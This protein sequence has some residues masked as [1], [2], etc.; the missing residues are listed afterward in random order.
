MKNLGLI[1]IS[2]SIVACG[3]SVIMVYQKRIADMFSKSSGRSVA[4]GEFVKPMPLEVGQFAVY[5]MTNSD[6]KKKCDAE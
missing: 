3:A 6:G 5:G 4:A 2:L 1:L